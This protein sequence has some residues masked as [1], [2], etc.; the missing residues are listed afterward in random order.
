MSVNNPRTNQ[1]VS[2]HISS[3]NDVNS[4]INKFPQKG[5]GKKSKYTTHYGRNEMVEADLYYRLL[6]ENAALKKQIIELTDK[7]KKMDVTMKYHKISSSTVAE[8]TDIETLK[9]ENQNLKSKNSKMK[10]I[11]SGLQTELRRK[12]PKSALGN[13]N[14]MPSNYEKNEYLEHIA[15]LQEALKIKYEEN[16]SLLSQLRDR[17]DVKTSLRITEYC[18]DLS[19]KN[20]KL[21][22]L[23]AKYDKVMNQFETN[24]KILTLTKEALQEYIEKFTDERNKNR[25]LENQ[26]QMNQ[27]TLDK[28]NEYVTIIEEY[29]KKEKLLEERIND[30]CENPFIKQANERDKAFL[31]LREN[32]IAL[33]EL[34]RKYKISEDKRIELENKIKELMDKLN[35][36]EMER[37]QFKEDALRYKISTEEKERQNKEFDDQFK[38]ISQ[39]GEV[40][41][42]YEKILAMLRNNSQLNKDN[43]GGNGS[44]WMD[45]NFLEK[46]DNLPDDKEELKKEVQRL[47]IEK[48]ILG[49]ELEKTKSLLEIQQ[50]INND[51]KELKEVDEKKY[52][53]EIRILQD[54]IR[55]LL[56]LLDKERI[57]KEYLGEK[58]EL[59]NLVQNLIPKAD[60]KNSLLLT[61]KSLDD[62]IT[63]FSNDLSESEYGINDNAVDLIISQATFDATAIENKLNI[64]L[65][66]LLS[67]ITI[68]FYLHESQ[69][70]NLV[71]GPSP[72]YNFQLT[73]KVYEDEHLI[74]YLNEDYM[75]IELYY[76]S[77]NKQII[78][79]NGKIKLDQL[80]RA[81]SNTKSRVVHGFC[82]MFFIG[83][84]SVRLGRIKYKM[85]MRNSIKNI[86]KWIN[87]KQGIVNQM[88]AV[89]DAN[90]KMG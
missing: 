25:D 71:N 9:I 14:F 10:T 39:F 80:I 59:N 13:K 76:L 54:K 72:N 81:E 3:E 52:N 47:I 8:S 33:E 24:V 17:D 12:N 90:S 34:K 28:V 42:N 87:D 23:S 40:D 15:Y 65:N 18:N 67:F 50:Q 86:L 68:D 46:M 37:D 73:F 19:E 11:I 78:F 31:K 16:Q 22:E 57:P 84:E 75:I 35:L 89:N 61:Q 74:N 26:L 21:A 48:G 43:K 38:R 58:N 20:A 53:K 64:P 82:E 83:D 32:E 69:T 2:M 44:P 30:L 29:K 60:G 66:D 5:A 62:K 45:I 70:S 85:R 4:K 7:I 79:G 51:L 77:N 49:T 41:S 36:T 1:T 6:E 63:E 27:A 55:E 88:S 56:S